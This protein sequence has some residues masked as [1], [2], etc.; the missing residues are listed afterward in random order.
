M[1]ITKTKMSVF[2][3]IAV[4]SFFAFLPLYARTSSYPLAV[5]SGNSMY[6]SLQNGDLV[7]YKSTDTDHILNGTV[8]VFVQSGTG[9]SLLDDLL[10]PVLIHR[11]VGEEVQPDGSV[12]YETKGDNNN[13][14]DPFVTSSS[15]VLGVPVL[16]IPKVGFLF[17][18]L[19]SP[20]G[21]IAVVGIITLGYLGF[22][23]DK[24]REEKKKD[25]FLGALARKVI[26]DQI[27]SEQFKQLE[28]AVKYTEDFE[29]INPKG[30]GLE[31][32]V[33][34]LK[35]GS[36]DKDWKIRPILCRKCSKNA[37]EL[38]AEGDSIAICSHC[39]KITSQNPT[40]ALTENA[41][42]KLVLESIDEGLFSLGKDSKALVYHYL[43]QEH[44][45]NRKDIP[46]RL[47]D[48]SIV[49]GKI[50]GEGSANLDGLFTK[51]LNSKVPS[52]RIKIK[53]N[54]R[55]KEYVTLIKQSLLTKKKEETTC[56]VGTEQE[57]VLI[58]KPGNS[59]KKRRNVQ[60]SQ[61]K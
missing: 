8:I 17:L 39:N 30:S 51:S 37:L 52:V 6:P 58:M 33:D 1:K 28:L 7:F 27:S 34:W 56:L 13:E 4:I 22:Y 11:V 38:E 45:I 36:L 14:N 25:K 19:Q 42:N 47:D 59:A 24:R 16:V 3:I 23:D 26:N 50:L 31:I 21:L 48:F 15:N 41:L 10:R 9:N 61:L 49:M 29:K 57:K 20:Q 35:K 44:L 46:E 40:V 2:I 18:F 60:S 43:T 12:G 5:V 32:F 54:T 53:K 55:F